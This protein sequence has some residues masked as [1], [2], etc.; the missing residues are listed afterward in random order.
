MRR[1]AG[2]RGG[3][4]PRLPLSPAQAATSPAD[5]VL[6]SAGADVTRGW[7]HSPTAAGL[8]EAA[9]NGGPHCCIGQSKARALKSD[10]SATG[11]VGF[12][13]SIGAFS[14]TLPRDRGQPPGARC[15]V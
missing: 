1:G 5:D 14:H 7:A 6:P 11:S 3:K 13:L 15:P 10:V 9:T 4:A 12:T 8:G 2:G